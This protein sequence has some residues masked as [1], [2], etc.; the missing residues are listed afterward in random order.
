VGGV[1]RRPLVFVVEREP[2]ADALR[3]LGFDAT[4]STAGLTG[5][6]LIVAPDASADSHRWALATA[7]SLVP[8]AHAVLVVDLVGGDDGETIER[9]Y[10]G[11]NH[12]KRRAQARRFV[13]TVVRR[14][15]ELRASR[16]GA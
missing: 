3:R 15:H 4:T 5:C 8:V 7:T 14:H 16:G 6:D 9:F 10:S 11:P 12:D 13:L 2:D 1:N